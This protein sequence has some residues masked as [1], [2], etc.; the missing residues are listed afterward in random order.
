MA[1]NPPANSLLPLCCGLLL[2]V[3]CGAWSWHAHLARSDRPTPLPAEHLQPWML[4]SLHGVGVK[5]APRLLVDFQAGGFAAL[6][7]PVQQQLRGL[8]A[9]I[10]AQGNARSSVE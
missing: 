7:S 2:I 8:I 6:P 10:P 9:D 1:L 5:T 4:E 3:G